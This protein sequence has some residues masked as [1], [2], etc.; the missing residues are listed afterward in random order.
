[1]LHRFRTRWLAGGGALLLVLSMSGMAAA[2]TI[3]SDTTSE[4]QDAT[5]PAGDTTPSVTFQDLNGD[6]IDDTCQTAVT[7][8]SVAAAAALTAADL[9]GDGAISVSEAAQSDWVGGANCNHGGYVSSVANTSTD[10]CA[11]ADGSGDGTNESADEANGDTA[12]G[13]AE[14]SGD[15]ATDTS[16]TTAS[17]TTTTCT[18]T[19]TDP[20]T[21]TTDP[22]STVCPVVAPVAPTDGTTPVVDSAP[23]A[24]GLAVSTVAQSD[25]VGGK[26][27]NH[28]GAVSE[29]ARAAH[30]L[31][32][33]QAAKRAAHLARHHGH[34]HGGQH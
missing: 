24:H 26:N 5:P 21:N 25:A 27:C 7:P 14:D 16:T 12:D 8:D 23:N 31:T 6:G 33:D 34:G 32:P 13:S 30:G 10:G 20:S 22:A 29:A 3:V 11:Q 2:A 28:G 4:T 15:Q 18:P 17:T 1:M 19:S 9:N